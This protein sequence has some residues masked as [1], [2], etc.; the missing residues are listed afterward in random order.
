MLENGRYIL[1]PEVASFEGAFASY[2]NIKHC[3]G[4]ASGTD[5]LEI[6]LR[7]CGIQAGDEVFTVSHTAVATVA[8][9]E[10]CGAKAILVDIDPATYTMNPKA[11]KEAI[12]TS[13]QP[14]AIIP[15]H[16]YGCPADMALIL[17][18]ARQNN[19]KVIEDSAQAHGASLNGKKTGTFGDLAAFSFYPTKNLGALGDGGA[20]VTNN[21][22]LAEKVLALR[23]YGWKKHF[24]SEIPGVNSRLDELQAAVLRVKLKYLDEENSKRREIACLYKHQLPKTSLV[25]PKAQPQIQAVFH[26]YV[27]RTKA[28]D[29]L[30]AFLETHSISTGIHYPVPVHLQPAYRNRITIAKKGLQNTEKLCSEILSLPIYPQIN[31]EDVERVCQVIGDWEKR[32]QN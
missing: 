5:A 7:S 12:R 9:I 27:V 18:I 11:L 17:E 14:K 2:L 6:A 19:L 26:Q 13:R 32:Q 16:L 31:H 28:R 4:V 25:L 1:G 3:I 23:E 21:P 24:I 22:D 8:A 30:K 10:R 20:V 15:V 29:E